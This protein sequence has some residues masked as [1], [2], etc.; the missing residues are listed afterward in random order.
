ME[1]YTQNS[2]FIEVQKNWS[3]KGHLGVTSKDHEAIFSTPDDILVQNPGKTLGELMSDTEI[4]EYILETR[5][6]I[7]EN[8]GLQ[9]MK[10]Y[11]EDL[12]KN[13]EVSIKYLKSIGRLSQDFV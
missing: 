13:L 6:N 5:K 9:N 3:E 8:E 2:E 12:K 1:R 4:Q 7:L 11:N 10:N